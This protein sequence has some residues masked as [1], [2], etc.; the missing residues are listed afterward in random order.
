MRRLII[1][2]AALV[3]AGLASTAIPRPALA[4][5]AS[6]GPSGAT[7]NQAPTSGANS[8]PQSQTP[9]RTGAPAGLATPRP[10]A[11]ATPVPTAASRPAWTAMPEPAPTATPKPAVA[12]PAPAKFFGSG[13]KVKMYA[14]TGTTP[15]QITASILAHGPKSNWIG[16]RAEALTSTSITYNITMVTRVSTGDCWLR[17]GS[18]A[19]ALR[20][21]VTLPRWVAPRNPDPRTVA[22]WNAEIADT[23]AHERVHVRL[24]AAAARKMSSIA[25]HSTCGNVMSRIRKVR[26]EARKANCE[27]DM[28]EYGTDEGLSLA[29]CLK[30]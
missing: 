30:S 2:V 10:A 12:R 23:A 18:P 8:Q 22:W 21:T 5:E 25:G 29:A 16:E 11:R 28:K 27:F 6:P 4:P 14:V 7:S 20:T 26:A 13:V 17:L 24:W 3:L 9:E 1:V 19:V 15:E